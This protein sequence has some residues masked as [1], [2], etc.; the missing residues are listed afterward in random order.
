[1]FLRVRNRNKNGKR[2]RYWSIVEN[3]R[4]CGGR[5]VQR[6]VLHLGELNDTQRAG[7]VRAIEALEPATERAQQLALFPDDVQSLPTLDYPIVQ[8]RL[9]RIQLR[10]PRQWGACWLTCQLWDML[11]LDGFWNER[12]GLSRKG[13]H[14]LH[15]LK[16]L[17]AYRLIDPGSEF[18]LHRQWFERSAMADLLGASAGV[19]GKNTLYRCL[20]RLL[21]HRQ[22]LFSHLTQRWRTLFHT[23]YDVLLY[24][25]TSTYFECDPPE[26]CDDKRRFGYSRDHRPDCVQVVIGLVVTP[27]GLPLGYEIYPGNTNDATTL[28]GFLD[29][30]E[31]QYGRV[32]RVWLMDRGIP[33]EETLAYMRSQGTFYLVGTPKGRLNKLEQSLLQQP[34]HQAREQVRVKWLPS[35]GEFYLY[36]ESAARVTK[37]RAMRRRRLKRLL[38]RLAQLQ[39][40]KQSRDAL[41]MRLGEARRQAGRTW[42]LVDIHVPGKNQPVT[43]ETFT[44]SLSRAKLR[45]WRRR[46]GRYLLRSNLPQDEPGAVWEKYL[47]LT[48]VEQAFKELKND[49]SIRPIHHQCQLRIEAHIFVSFLAYCLF[50]TLRNLLRPS[51]TGLTSR[52][53]IDTF[54]QM[55]MIDVHLPTTDGRVIL[56]QRYTEPEPEVQL[57]LDRLNLRLPNQPPPRIYD[58]GAPPM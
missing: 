37:E 18:R 50:T 43:P 41:L 20:D 48:Q 57:L 52:S 49:L 6:Q 51:A 42:S 15:V 56:L 24:D 14:W 3:R 22:A 12:L 5:V 44:F 33:T 58:K 34:W 7:W 29:R 16:T 45:R 8:I 28:R 4:V 36:V 55:Q 46:E 31:A 21:E 13:T 53:V 35:E 47:L 23:H 38:H 9:D 11:G 40:M 54:S 39:R 17:V 26:R 27:E 19:A 10:R 30:I 25:L 32:N 2:H 1:M